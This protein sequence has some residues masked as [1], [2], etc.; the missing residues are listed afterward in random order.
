MDYITEE[1]LEEVVADLP[2]DQDAQI[3]RFPPS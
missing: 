2:A 1:I 3:Y